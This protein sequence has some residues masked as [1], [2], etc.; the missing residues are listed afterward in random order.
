MSLSL[1]TF[2]QQAR[3]LQPTHSPPLPLLFVCVV[4]FV[5][6]SRTNIH[7]EEQ[8]TSRYT[9]KYTERTIATQTHILSGCMSACISGLY[10]YA[11]FLLLSSYVMYYISLYQS[12]YVNLTKFI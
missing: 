7:R 9:F 6:E 10:I 4:L 8:F 11:I 12:I 3:V 5:C 2:T 1:K